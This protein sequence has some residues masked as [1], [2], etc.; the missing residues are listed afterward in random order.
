MSHTVYR[1]PYHATVVGLPS[2]QRPAAPRGLRPN[3][4]ARRV[5]AVAVMFVVLLV[6]L[7][8]LVLLAGLGGRPASA[9]QA[10]PAHIS[11]DGSAAA[12][13]AAMAYVA[14]PGDTLWSVASTHHG[15]APLDA[16]L[17]ALIDLNGGTT[18]QV[19][20]VVHLP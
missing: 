10:E 14:G 20:Q 2:M 12:V 7:A 16:Y 15:S 8:V 19:G 18:V 13:R 1:S 3:Y 4:A 11:A 9:S 6:A 5:M 17:D